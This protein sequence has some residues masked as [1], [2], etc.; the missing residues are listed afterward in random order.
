MEKRKANNETTGKK[1]R[2]VN[3]WEKEKENRET[4][5]RK[6]RIRKLLGKKENK[7]TILYRRKE[8]FGDYLEKRKDNETTRNTGK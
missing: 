1:E 5:G 4:T 3:Y 6:G 8:R 2:Y 7:E